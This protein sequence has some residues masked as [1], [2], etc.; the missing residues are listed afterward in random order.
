MSNRIL[1]V[2][3]DKN[4]CELLGKIFSLEGFETFKAS[5]GRAALKILETERVDFMIT[6]LRMPD[7][8]GLELY[9]NSRQMHPDLPTIIIT[10]F[11]TVDNAVQAL[12]EGVYDYITKPVD[13]NRLLAIVSRA[14]EAQSL[15]AENLSTS[16]TQSQF[17]IQISLNILIDF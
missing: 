9:Q 3:D 7:M 5:S 10:A 1:I 6:D 11:G 4:Q 13:T 17:L 12:K 2:D 14:L 16:R 8:T 15:K